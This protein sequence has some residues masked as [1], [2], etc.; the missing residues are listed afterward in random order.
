MIFARPRCSQ[1][2]FLLVQTDEKSAISSPIHPR[3]EFL[4]VCRTGEQYRKQMKKRFDWMG[5]C[6][7]KVETVFQVIKGML[8]KD[9]MF[10]EYRGRREEEKNKHKEDKGKNG[11]TAVVGIKDRVTNKISAQPVS[12]TTMIRLEN[13][14]DS[15]TTKEAKKYTDENA[16]YSN[17]QNHE[18]VRHSVGEYV[19]G[20]AHVNGMESFWSMVRRG[21][22]GVYHHISEDHLHRYINEFAGRH[23]V[24]SM[25][26]IEMMGQVA[27]NMMGQRLTYQ[28]L[29]SHI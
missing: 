5:H 7:P 23:N 2:R 20:Q 28:A 14:I 3:Y 11:K 21:Y 9:V 10:R 24:R 22:D 17:L 25:D 27:E 1:I 12:E 18:S 13:F 8:G 4:P 15:K 29:I 26:T 16:S 19:R 6:D